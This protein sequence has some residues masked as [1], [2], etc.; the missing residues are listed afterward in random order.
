MR[1]GKLGLT[2][3]C[4]VAAASMGSVASAQWD[5][6]FDGYA[7]GS[8]ILGQGGWTA[9]DGDSLWDSFVTSDQSNS[10]ANSLDVL[11]DS[12]SI[13]QFN[14]NMGTIDCGEWTLTCQVYVPSGLV[15]ADDTYFILLNHYEHGLGGGNNWST[16]VH[17]DPDTGEVLTDSGGGETTAIVY[18]TW[19]E[20]RVVINLD[21]DNQDFYYDGNLFFS[22]SWTEGVSGGGQLE[23]QAMDLFAFG[24]TS[25]YYD[26][27]TMNQTGDCVAPPCLELTLD[28]LLG[29][30]KSTWTISGGTE[31]DT[32][33][34]VYGTRAGTTAGEQLGYCFDFGIK[35]VNADKLICQKQLGAGGT[36]D[37]TKNI[38][39]GNF[40]GLEILTQAAK[41]AT[42]PDPCMS[43]IVTEV[44]G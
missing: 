3:A 5:E 16:Q 41:K 40:I 11:G 34:L 7:V 21:T 31:G 30:L 8:G 42:C 1:R 19:T 4:A 23:I 35:G 27:F 26:D 43:N 14:E 29:N 18:D 25:V 12:D 33:A 13:Y 44:I 15:A 36:V 10:T 9:W 38:P 6:N 28:R 2:I 32:V 39:G 20:I 37:C 17:F 22:D 24:A